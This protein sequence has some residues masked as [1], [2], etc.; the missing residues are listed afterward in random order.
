MSTLLNEHEV[1]ARLGIS[2]RT[3][4]KMR[5]AG[6]SLRFVKIG[7]SVRYRPEDV[8][9]FVTGNVRSSTSDTGSA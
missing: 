2:H 9:A 5:V 4:Q 7:N 6:S 8:E 1:A 3:I